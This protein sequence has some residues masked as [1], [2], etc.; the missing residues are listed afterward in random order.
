M[1]EVGVENEPLVLDMLEWI[2]AEPRPYDA[3][4]AAWR[5][6]CPR[7]TVWEDS[8]DAGLVSIDFDPDSR[9]TVWL[10]PAGRKLLR[11]AGRNTSQAT[12][13]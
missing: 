7:L 5:T 3:V 6:S 2:G 4:L 11:R 10:T 12:V 8:C 1:R 9:R 13:S